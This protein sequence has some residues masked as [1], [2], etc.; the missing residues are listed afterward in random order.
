VRLL[1]ELDSVGLAGIEAKHREHG[2][3]AGAQESV[4]EALCELERSTRVTLL[5]SGA[6]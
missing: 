3:R 6:L 5:H 4:I 1:G 2:Q